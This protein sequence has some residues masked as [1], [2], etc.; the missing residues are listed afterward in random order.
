MHL[1]DR[2]RVDSTLKACTMYILFE[3]SAGVLQP[4]LN[5]SP[6][7]LKPTAIIL[8]F[9]PLQVPVSPTSFI[10]H[11]RWPLSSDSAECL[12]PDES[13]QVWQARPPPAPVTGTLQG[14][15]CTSV[16][17]RDT[18]SRHSRSRALLAQ[19]V[20]RINSWPGSEYSFVRPTGPFSSA[21]HLASQFHS[22]SRAHDQWR[23]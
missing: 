17:R 10:R 5:V 22:H 12:V 9:S 20:P 3:V 18:T 7:K 11:H 6:A 2:T 1:P 21:F 23:V 16:R 4:T 13:S 14:E 19:G 8:F 15:A